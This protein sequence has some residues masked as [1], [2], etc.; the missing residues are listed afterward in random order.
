MLSFGNKLHQ[1]TTFTGLIYKRTNHRRRK[2]FHDGL[3]AQDINRKVTHRS[4]GGRSLL[5]RP[6]A[7]SRNCAGAFKQSSYDNDLTRAILRVAT[8]CGA[9]RLNQQASPS[10]LTPISLAA[11]NYVKERE[12]GAR[13]SWRDRATFLVEICIHKN[14]FL[15]LVASWLLGHFCRFGTNR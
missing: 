2:A 14:I 13:P 1:G 5:P 8:A 7:A 15:G 3:S 10:L 9:A 6:A 11:F 12:N 4:R